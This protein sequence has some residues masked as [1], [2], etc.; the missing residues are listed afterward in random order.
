[1]LYETEI[2]EIDGELGFIIPDEL[3]KSLNWH[4]GDELNYEL[5]PKGFA[6]SLS[7]PK[8]ASKK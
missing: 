2:I 6:F 7:K 4:E 5:T 8:E 1:M 3:I